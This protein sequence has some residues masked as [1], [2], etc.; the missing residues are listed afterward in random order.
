VT[1]GGAARAA[2]ALACAL[3]CALMP[4]C[5][6]LPNGRGPA[7]GARVALT[8]DDGPAEPWTARLLDLLAARR[9]RATFFVVGANVARHPDLARRIVAEGHEI[10]NHT[11]THS[12][13][14]TGAPA[15]TLAAE[16]RDGEAA[17]AAATGRR[18]RLLRWP[19][20]VSGPSGRRARSTA[21]ACGCV[22]VHYTAAGRDLHAAD[23]AAIADLV[24]AAAAPGAILALHDGHHT[25][26]RCDQ[27]ATVAAV[28][29]IL[30]G[31]A[32]RGLTPVPVGELLGEAPYRD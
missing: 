6:G 29:R 17:I 18:P 7:E 15:T 27:S 31:L 3:A 20:G 1:G 14:L 10:A 5:A 28:A 11:Y 22:I 12:Y 19:V 9:V 2:G 23:P 8:F 4:G 25:Y 26:A 32:A 24:L 30:D 21:D 13:L 16:V